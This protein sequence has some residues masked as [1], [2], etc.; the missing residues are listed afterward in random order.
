MAVHRGTVLPP[1]SVTQIGDSY[2]V[3][4]SHHG[5]SVAKGRGA[6]TINATSWPPNAPVAT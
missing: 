2:A 4:D 6:P 1:V 5:V 3:R